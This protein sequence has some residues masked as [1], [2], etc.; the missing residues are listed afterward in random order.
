MVSLYNTHKTENHKLLESGI[1]IIV[2]EGP[3]LEESLI[4]HVEICSKGKNVRGSISRFNEEYS[5]LIL[6][7]NYKSVS[8]WG[9]IDHDSIVMNKLMN[10]VPFTQFS[11]LNK[12]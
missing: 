7:S 4:N 11:Y 8:F 9:I 1:G 2:E 12:L 6:V 3:S 10:I 5:K